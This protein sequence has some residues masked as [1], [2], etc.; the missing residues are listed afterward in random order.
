LFILRPEVLIRGYVPELPNHI[1]RV[2]QAPRQKGEN[3]MRRVNA[4]TFL[5]SVLP[6]VFLVAR[7][8][9]AAIADQIGW[10]HI[11]LLANWPT[12]FVSTVIYYVAN[13]LSAFFAGKVMEGLRDASYWAVNRT[14]IFHLAPERERE[15]TRNNAIIWLATAVGSAAAGLG[16]AF[17]GFSSTILVLILA[18][19]A[20][21]IP[22]ALLWKTGKKSSKPQNKSILKLLDPRGKSSA[23]WWASVALMFNSLATYPLITLL[24]PVFMQQQMAYGYIL[25]GVLFMLYNAIASATTFLTL[26]IALSFRRAVIQSVV[27]LLASIFLAGSGFF[28]PAFLFALAFV[29]GFSVAFFE[30]LVAKVAKDSQNVCVD[31]GWLHVPMRLAEFSSVLFAG[32]V[33]QAVGYA[34]VFAA[35]GVFFAVFSFMS[36][37]QLT[38]GH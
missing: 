2:D 7:L 37:H 31:I 8:L 1:R 27:A 17:T 32:F 29:R 5:L 21:G 16:I 18:S 28:F 9:F 3:E 20:I 10:S 34:P 6:L 19:A 26:R 15:A 30:H 35:T 36:L 22:A 4:I 11:F 24:L 13:S 33:A 12:T 25:I 14:A 38:Q 23:F